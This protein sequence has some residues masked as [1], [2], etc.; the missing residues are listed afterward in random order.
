MGDFTVY[1][2][3]RYGECNKFPHKITCHNS[4]VI[5]AQELAEWMSSYYAGQEGMFLV[6]GYEDD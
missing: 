2:S 4:T 6:L 1:N 5:Q 3:M